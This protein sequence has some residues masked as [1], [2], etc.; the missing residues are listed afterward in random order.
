MTDEHAAL[1]DALDRSARAIAVSNAPIAAITSGGARR[2]KRRNHV[3][4]AGCCLACATG[5]IGLA[6][7]IHGPS[8][9]NAGPSIASEV[10]R[11]EAPEPLR[12]ACTPSQQRSFDLDVPGPGAS[13]PEQAVET[14][15]DD[16]YTFV[17]FRDQDSRSVSVYALD[18]T[19]A[20]TREYRVSE[21][22]DGWWPDSFTSCGTS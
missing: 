19:G 2:R 16:G 22:R 9:R 5:A 21:R 1:I 13:S 15:S 6:L 3:A 18:S 14:V 12:L 8:G 20:V 4:I 7:E 17:T 11:T 10:S